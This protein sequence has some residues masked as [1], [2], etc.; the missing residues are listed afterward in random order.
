M[1]GTE[2]QLTCNLSYYFEETGQN[3]VNTLKNVLL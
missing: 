3:L 1:K 2:I